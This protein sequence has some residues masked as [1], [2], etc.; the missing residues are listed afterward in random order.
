VTTSFELEKCNSNGAALGS[1]SLALCGGI[2]RNHNTIS[3]DCF[4]VN[5]CIS[6][7]YAF[8]VDQLC[9]DCHI[10]EIFFFATYRLL[11]HSM[12]S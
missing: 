6:Y 12:I 4:P 2:F 7:A 3:L 1:P 10:N 11:A 8:N 5:F 9:Y